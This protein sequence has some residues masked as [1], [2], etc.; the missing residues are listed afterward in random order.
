MVKKTEDKI[1][2]KVLK[3]D[4]HIHSVASKK[5]GEEVSE[6]TI[7]NIQILIDKL[8]SN[9]IDMI[10]VTDHNEFDIQL[11]E[12]LKE[13][14]K[15]GEIKKVL[16]GI[17][18]DVDFKGKRIHII[19][20]FND[21]NEK[22]IE[23][24]SKVINIP[25]DNKE[26][27]P[28]AYK[29]ATLRNILTNIE[30]DVL[31]IAHQKSGVRGGNQNEN[32][33]NIGEDKF[34]EIIGI[35]YFDA[36]E[37]K[38]GKIEG[39]LKSYFI[40]KELP[41][42]KYI[43]GTDCHNWNYYPKRNEKDKQE[44]T[45]SFLRC[46]PTFKGVVMSLTDK[47]R[48]STAY[49]NM[50]KPYLDSLELEFNKEK[51]YI[52]L[53]P[54]LNV[55]IGDNSTGK[56]LILDSLYN[57][58]YTGFS[59]NKK[60]GYKAF[61]K[62]HDLKIT[63]IPKEKLGKVMYDPQGGIRQKFEG[64]TKLKD[65]KFLSKNFK[66]LNVNNIKE[67]I[68]TYIDKVL[69]IIKD[70]QKITDAKNEL[71][72]EV[73]F[74]S[75]IDKT[76]HHLRF[77]D[78]LKIDDTDYSKLIE[79][80]RIILKN[81]E[82]LKS[83]LENSEI[84]LIEK[85]IKFIKQVEIKIDVKNEKILYKNKII[86]E[87]KKISNRIEKEISAVS[88]E[89]DNVISNQKQV[90]I[91]S[92]NRIIEMIKVNNLEKQDLF[93]KF[94]EIKVPSKENGLGDY[95]FVTRTKELIIDKDKLAELLKSPL[96]RVNDIT[97]VIEMD[98]KTFES[99]LKTTIKNKDDDFKKIYTDEVLKV[100]NDKFLKQETVILYNGADITSGNSPGKNAL[101]Y[102]EVLSNDMGDKLYIVDQPSDDIS[103]IK[104]DEIIKIMKHIALNK[105]VLFVTHKPE[106]VVNLDVDNVVVLKEEEGKLSVVSGALEFES[107]KNKINILNEVALILDGGIETIR[108]RW[109]RYEKKD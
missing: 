16:P 85:A 55:I 51:I 79:K 18:F 6:N 28:N 101:I 21:A 88:E 11:Y 81:L 104:S 50:R 27:N 80:I 10:A 83:E 86:T 20:L 109:K 71:D 14:E 3:V 1:V 77:S 4:F 98:E 107:K 63:E 8:K 82:D 38:T 23:N 45:F 13:Y 87:I 75:E 41:N 15:T 76:I 54:R 39:M 59:T 93:E 35:D 48:V 26:K 12:K 73:E 36:L 46:L 37:F 78:D 60:N 9:K 99:K 66:D 103:R 95:N 29:E 96:S 61:L 30:T 57:K 74:H 105:Q 64:G 42:F 24:I 72:F 32:L 67:E 49:S 19:C 69:S 40:E 22:K 94:K 17:E 100:L 5:D 25:F 7:D 90:E 44:M 2:N 56:S 91:E 108:R 68:E 97:K 34:D 52:P 89:Q 92:K 84:K 43:T 62:N 58:N 31:L 53:S 102:F 106:L 47:D 70:N 65:V 33:A